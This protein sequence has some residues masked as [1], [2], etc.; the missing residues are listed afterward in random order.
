MAQSE[1][2]K[3]QHATQVAIA[4]AQFE[5]YK[6][7]IVKEFVDKF[8]GSYQTTKG[9]KNVWREAFIYTPECEKFLTEK[10]LVFIGCELSTNN[11]RFQSPTF[12]K[13]LIG[14]ISD[15]LS[16]Y[17]AKKGT[18]K[19]TCKKYLC[20]LLLKSGPVQSRIKEYVKQNQRAWAKR[21]NKKKFIKN[22]PETKKSQNQAEEKT[23]QKRLRER[24]KK[25][26]VVGIHISSIVR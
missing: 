1:S 12:F 14:K 16:A 15:Y 2:L 21:Q 9:M 7:F 19:N 22:T 3:K 11:R 25:I 6:N 4:E 10:T 18:P 20:E 8:G 24:R 17:V 26:L 5:A 13:T 23:T